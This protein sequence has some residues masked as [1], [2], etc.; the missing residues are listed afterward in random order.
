M[1]MVTVV[2][3]AH[4]GDFLL[5]NA[6]EPCEI[7][8]ERPPLPRHQFSVTLGALPPSSDQKRMTLLMLIIPGSDMRGANHTCWT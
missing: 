7:A 5:R 2:D 1:A 6:D 3:G 4:A 8:D